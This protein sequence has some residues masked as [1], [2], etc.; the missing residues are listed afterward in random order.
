M[1]SSLLKNIAPAVLSAFLLAACGGEGYDSLMNSA[2]TALSKGESKA[3]IIQ[4]KNA[5]Q[6]NPEAGEARFLLGKAFLDSGDARSAEVELRKAI[7]A[8]FEPARIAPVMARAQLALQAYKPMIELYGEFKLEDAAARADLKTS[9][10]TAFAATGVR[11]KS[12]AALQE[13]LQA[14]P[15]FAPAVLLQ[16]RLKLRD[17]DAQGALQ[18]LNGLL[19][20]DAT[21]AEGWRLKGDVVL[22]SIKSGA[23]GSKDMDAAEGIAAYRQALVLAPKDLGAHAGLINHWIEAGEF[24]KAAA[25]LENLKKALPKDPQSFYFDAL[26]AY[27]RKDFAAARGP[28][29]ELL[30]LAPES[31][32]A[33]QLGGAIEYELKA[34]APAEEMLS[35]ALKLA[36]NLSAP[37]R[38]LTQIYLLTSSPAKAV[39]A[40][41]PLLLN[42]TPDAQI[43]SLA[44][45]AYLQNG[46]PKKAETYFAQAAKLNPKDSRSRT[47]LILGK[48]SSAKPEDVL[49]DLKS[50]SDSDPSSV[51]D[52][53]I[54]RAHLQRR[55][56][57]KAMAAIDVLERKQPKRP[58]AAN[59]RGLVLLARKDVAGAKVNFEKALSLDPTFYPAAAL[60]ASLD[61][62]DKQPDAAKQ[63]F[64]TLL[65]AAPDNVKAHLALAEL[66][67][68]GGA[69]KEEVGALI[70]KA[71]LIK[72]TDA[73]PRVAL[74]D[75][76]LKHRDLKAAQIAAQ[77]G[78]AALPEAPELLEVQGRVRMLAGE[79]NQATESFN[80]LARVMPRS[81]MPHMRLA[82]AYVALK[83]FPNATASLKRALDLAPDYLV[84]RKRLAEVYLAAG[85]HK[86]ALASATLMQ[87]Q[88]A[89]KAAGLGLQ[90][91]VLAAQK[92]WV[93]AAAAYRQSLAAGG[94]ANVDVAAG[95][96][97]K[98]HHA[99]ALGPN[100]AEAEK[101]A[102]GWIKDHP[103]DAV[104]QF[105]LGGEEL[106]QGK[107][108]PAETR[109]AAVLKLQPENAPALNNMAWLLLK[110]GKP[111]ALPLI[112]KANQLAPK[113]A[114]FLDT[115]SMI[116]EAEKQ[117]PKAIEVQSQALDLQPENHEMRMRLAKLYLASG[118]KT[119]AGAELQ[120]L[121]KAG[122]QYGGQAEVQ[123]L[124]R[125]L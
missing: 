89:G 94:D 38:M 98:L 111:G 91:D 22:G 37:R 63:R 16:V 82:E 81:P 48:A 26:L 118:D 95:L 113:Q 123:Q 75:H 15:G 42:G 102:A 119:K 58:I 106:L 39:A 49:A 52:I 122:K 6:K 104:F 80:A 78:I 44:G 56:L 93:G 77:K 74:V 54:I 9:L 47:Q 61:M 116:L 71:V 69:T 121:A 117:L 76:H 99:L 12:E 120:R 20:S 19:K 66:K 25:D 45:E 90:G 17:G 79:Y 67:E 5:L 88:E 85:D 105:Y 14:A 43:Y 96:A 125:A 41:Q 13:A 83:N 110:Q 8:K 50:I 87:K 18:V 27:S 51:A 92:D 103:K 97:S 70:E 23:E 108:A 112:E 34:F 60:L 73:A 1:T 24:D 65:K 64:E 35:K 32:L 109:F 55:D 62:A 31:P 124:L 3:A 84:A 46:D 4:L 29:Q 107:L 30:T 10:A 21:Q 2:R 40:I 68:I 101:F 72:P 114:E 100:K 59:L 57:D 53:A 115:F 36:P 33:L 86:N 7:A 28:V 11:D